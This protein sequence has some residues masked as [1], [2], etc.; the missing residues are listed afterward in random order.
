MPHNTYKGED[1]LMLKTLIQLYK[2]KVEGEKR[3][4]NMPKDTRQ[5]SAEV[6]IKPLFPSSL[7]STLAVQNVLPLKVF[8]HNVQQD[9]G[10]M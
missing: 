4:Q 10:F 1:L 9:L 5:V 3:G 2:A 6:G 7:D 8:L